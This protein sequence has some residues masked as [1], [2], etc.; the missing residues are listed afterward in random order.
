MNAIMHMV[1][2]TP[3]TPPWYPW[4]R[5]TAKYGTEQRTEVLRDMNC[6]NLSINGLGTDDAIIN[7]RSEA[8]KMVAAKI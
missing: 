2:V 3:G 6:T 1:R 7:K 4:Y 5:Y 8:A